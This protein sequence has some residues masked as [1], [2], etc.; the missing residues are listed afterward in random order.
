MNVNVAVRVMIKMGNTI[1][2]TKT[3]Y[4]H[5]LAMFMAIGIDIGLLIAVLIYSL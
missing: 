2:L 5:N 4:Y 3:M 1:T